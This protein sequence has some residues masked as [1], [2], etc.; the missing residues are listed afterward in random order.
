MV[1]FEGIDGTGKSTLIQRVRDLM[2][3]RGWEVVTSKEPTDGP[4]GRR[5]RATATSA[6]GRL[7][8]AEE[9]EAFLQDRREHVETLI[10]PS[11][12]AGR[13][14]LLDRYYFST[15]AYQGIRGSDPEELR[16]VN[17]AFAP[18]PDLLVILDLD[19]TRA[20]QRVRGR[21]DQANHFERLHLLEQSRAIFRRYVHEGARPSPDG[22]P[23]RAILLDATESP[24]AL[25]ARVESLL[26]KWSANRT[27]G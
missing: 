13:L 14:V 21:G 4:W 16:A 3:A 2:A 19:P 6:A 17:E 7:A 18:R 24:D 23:C 8:P 12:V 11:L 5:I 15:M 22:R 9:L 10:R 1:A 26:L 25:A 27:T 20:L